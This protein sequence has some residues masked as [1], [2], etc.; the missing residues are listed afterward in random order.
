[1][2]ACRPFVGH[3]PAHTRSRAE[4]RTQSIDRRVRLASR[5]SAAAAPGAAATTAPAEAALSTL[6]LA[7]TS[8][9]AVRPSEVLQALV[10]VEKA[11]LKADDWLATLTAPGTCWR[12][13][14]TVPGKDITAA[15]KKQK[16]GAGGFFPLAAC[17]K[18]DASGFEN[19]VFLGPL[20]HLTFKGGFQ[21]D[22]KL[23]HFDV[24]TMYLGLG[25]WRLAVPLK[26]EVPLSDMDSKTFKKLPFFVYAYVG[27][28]IVVARGRSGGVALWTRAGPQWLASSG[29]MQVYK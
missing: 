16:G 12:L 6:R 3:S 20:G 25:P 8:P 5:I 11:K 4:L 24:A 23:L 2:L 13:V 29:A 15:T 26:K 19:G 1:M 9:G 18:F 10:V 17:Q 27:S 7:A 21:M 22:G 14:Y 28:D